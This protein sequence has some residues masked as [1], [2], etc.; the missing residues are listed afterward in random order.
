MVEADGLETG[1]FS[2]SLN[3]LAL[4]PFA[5]DRF[6]VNDDIN[7]VFRILFNFIINVFQLYWTTFTY[8]RMFL[9]K[10]TN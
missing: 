4:D 9:K 5:I 6:I 10:S 8:I 2:N 1:W 7:I 3:K